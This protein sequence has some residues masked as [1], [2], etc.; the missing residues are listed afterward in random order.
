[1]WRS[2]ASARTLLKEGLIWRIGSGLEVNIWGDKW[3]PSPT[4]Y[5]IQSPRR[6]L[7]TNT[8]VIELID[9]GT[10]WWN[11]HLLHTLFL[12]EEVEVILRIPLSRYGQKDVLIWRG[13]TTSEF[14]VQSAYHMEQ[15]RLERQGGEGS[16][17]YLLEKYLGLEG[18]KPS[19]NVLM[20]GL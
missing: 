19:Q 3:L 16:D 7:P 1:L 10:K 13:S 17:E 11:W 5:T 9:Q 20:A 12:T 2:I 8:K 14:I 6:L 15:D 4:T 18:A